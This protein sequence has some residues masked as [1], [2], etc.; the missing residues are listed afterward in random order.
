MR[1]V[2]TRYEFQ[3]SAIMMSRQF[4]DG[5]DEQLIIDC[6]IEHLP[7]NQERFNPF[8]RNPN[9]RRLEIDQ[10]GNVGKYEVALRGRMLVLPHMENVTPASWYTEVQ[11]E[12]IAVGLN[13]LQKS[14][15]LDEIRA[16]DIGTGSMALPIALAQEGIGHIV[17]VEIS[18]EFQE[19]YQ[20]LAE[21]YDQTPWWNHITAIEGDHASIAKFSDEYFDLV[22][23]NVNTEPWPISDE[24]ASVVYQETIS[25]QR[26]HDGGYYGT[27]I[28]EE[29]I[30][31]SSRKLQSG[32][33]MVVQHPIYS[34]DRKQGE[35]AGEVT[36]AVLEK[37]G[38]SVVS[39]QEITQPILEGSTVG[40]RLRLYKD[41]LNWEPAVI[42]GFKYT[43]V[44][45][46]VARKR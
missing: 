1:G 12:G 24:E 4:V 22:F 10:L 11:A 38:C 14:R 15:R 16:L 18:P 45:L 20:T 6:P 44:C 17:A 35:Q 19:Y 28:L 37:A 7:L 3:G 31:L 25:H 39:Y 33:I 29:S 13:I 26:F 43:Q 41:K 9:M 46:F 40:N 2:E 27:E 21:M 23:S 34:F 30:A 8:I 36:A 32:G 5:Q 42:D